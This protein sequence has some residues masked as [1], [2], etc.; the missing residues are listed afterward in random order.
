MN[1]PS[2]AAVGA[3]LAELYLKGKDTLPLVAGE[4]NDAASSVIGTH[5]SSALSRSGELGLGSDGPYND[6]SAVRS[7][8]YSRLSKLGGQLDD[9]GINIMKTAQDLAD[10]DTTT[11]TA[12]KNHGGELPQ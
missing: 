9:C 6:F 7:N 1:A 11:E 8:L 2:G 5:F 12:F 3:E 4:I 10:V